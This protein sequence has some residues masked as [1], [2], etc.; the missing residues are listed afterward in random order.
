[1]K[2]ISRI[3]F[4]VFSSIS[5]GAAQ[6]RP[7]MFVF[8]NTNPNKPD[9][10]KEQVDSLMSAHLANIT[11]LANEGKIIA[12]GPFYD[13]GGIFVMATASKDTAWEWLKTDPAVRA[14]RWVLEIFPYQPLRGSVCSVGENYTMTTY[15]FVR[16]AVKE[17]ATSEESR[18][19]WDAHDRYLRTFSPADSVVAEGILGNRQ[20]SIFVYQGAAGEEFIKA[21]PTVR[22]GALHVTIRKI[23]I[24]KGSFCE[25]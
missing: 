19:A 4:I 6:P 5:F 9:L 2:N 22:E 23:Y 20:S 8:L 21:E 25:K 11:R 3:F 18:R 12:A 17:G 10:P 24:A 16:Y 13:G 1:M 14:N 15:N 7:F